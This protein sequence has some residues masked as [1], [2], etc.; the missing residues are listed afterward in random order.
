MGEVRDPAALRLLAQA[1]LVP[2]PLRF[3]YMAALRIFGWLALLAR[4]DHAKD[5]EI[6]LLRHQVAVLQRQ[7]KSPRVSWADRALL[8]ALARLLPGARLRQLRL[9]VSPRTLLR[10]HASLVRR[11][12]TYP[13]RAPGRPRT[14]QVIR[15][16]VLE[17]A[18][19][20]PGWGYRRVHGELTGLGYTLAPSTVW[21]ILKDGGIDP[22]PRRS[23]DSWRVFL[24]A[25]AK[26][27]LAVDFFHVDTVF[28]RRL[29]VLFFVEHGTRRVHMAGITAHPAGEWVTQQARNLMMALGDHAERFKFVI[30]D[31][32]AKFTA[33]FDAVFTA[34]GV[35][36]IKT[37]VQAPRAN[38]IAERWIAS[39]RRECLD[40]MLITGERHLRLVLGEYVEHFNSHRPHRTLRQRPPDEREHPP[41]MSPAARVLRRDRLGGLI[42]EYA[43]VA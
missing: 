31:R 5:A 39:A 24:E 17:M 11:R 1:H 14:A 27:I 42:H 36:I 15:A 32:D 19:D 41:A 22:A 9:I 35:R 6:L 43:Q 28:L 33:A 12:W 21:Q 16:L 7:V 34:I 37:P 25:Q 29:H 18:R 30:R 38:A 13:R 2:V 23:G 26:T 20:N 40:R 3:A 4:S 8:S 10:W